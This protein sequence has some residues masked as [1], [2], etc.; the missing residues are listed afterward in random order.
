MNWWD[1]RLSTQQNQ[2]DASKL[3]TEAKQAIAD[4][5]VELTLLEKSEPAER[6]RPSWERLV[7]VTQQHTSTHEQ[8]AGQ[9]ET[10]TVLSVELTSAADKLSLTAQ[11]LQSSKQAQQRQEQLITERK[12]SPLI[13][14]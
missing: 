14:R 4:A 10:K 2:L 5:Q 11:S 13:V 12:Y 3:N 9:H 8:M 1:K 6:L 7:E